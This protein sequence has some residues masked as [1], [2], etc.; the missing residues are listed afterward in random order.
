LLFDVEH[1]TAFAW[2]PVRFE[3]MGGIWFIGYKPVNPRPR[4]KDR[5]G[6]VSCGDDFVDRAVDFL[7]HF[8]DSSDHLLVCAVG[9]VPIRYPIPELWAWAGNR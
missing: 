4:V 3:G 1:R 2:S 9:V 6:V 8:L 5:R 7:A